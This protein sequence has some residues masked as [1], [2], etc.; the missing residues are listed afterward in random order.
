MLDIH[1]G[2]GADYGKMYAAKIGARGER[3]NI[4]VGET[5]INSDRLEDEKAGENEIAISSGIYQELKNMNSNLVS[6]FKKKAGGEY[7]ATIGFKEF[8]RESANLKHIKDTN[9]HSYNG[10]WYE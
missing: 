8:L 1:L 7:V 10:A 3:D 2:A 5:V 4:L 6:F 9:N